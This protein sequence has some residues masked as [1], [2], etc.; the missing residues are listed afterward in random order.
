MSTIRSVNNSPYRDTKRQPLKLR[1]SVENVKEAIRKEFRDRLKQLRNESLN[2]KRNLTGDTAN[3]QNLKNSIC[4]PSSELTSAEIM[5]ILEEINTEL[6]LES[7][8]NG[9]DNFVQENNAIVE[10]FLRGMN[11]CPICDKIMNQDFEDVVTNNICDQCSESF[12]A[13]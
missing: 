2:G 9:F 10:D 3:L 8:A 4:I 6:K 13:I 1:S 5:K 11:I 12:N 7:D